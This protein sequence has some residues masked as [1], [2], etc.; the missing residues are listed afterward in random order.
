MFFRMPLAMAMQSIPFPPPPERTGT[1][2]PM[3]RRRECATETVRPTT[4]TAL[5]THTKA[6]RGCGRRCGGRSVADG[7][8]D[9]GGQHAHVH[10][11]QLQLLRPHRRRRPSTIHA[12][13]PR[14]VRPS[15]RTTE[16]ASESDRLG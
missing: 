16:L 2:V 12:R 10:H 4:F 14:S 3:T 5:T 9:G 13:W 6:Y 15:V 11:H 8:G 1:R 7:R